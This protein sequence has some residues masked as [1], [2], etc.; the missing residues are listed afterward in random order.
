MG[1]RFT[2]LIR[3]QV[4]H[5]SAIMPPT[6]R[7][8]IRPHLLPRNRNT[9]V[10]SPPSSFP[11]SYSHSIPYAHWSSTSHLFASCSHLLFLFR[12]VLLLVLTNCSLH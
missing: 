3:I 11:A 7:F 6:S 4:A 9:A 1:G 5:T 10:H 12:L 2:T 8:A